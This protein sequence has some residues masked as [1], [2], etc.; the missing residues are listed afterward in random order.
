MRRPPILMSAVQR[1]ETVFGPDVVRFLF[2]RIED[3]RGSLYPVDLSRLPF[4]P[5]HMFFICRAPPGTARGGHARKTT[6]Q[7]LLC[8][9]G[10]IDVAVHHRGRRET[11]ELT[12]PG[13]AIYL[14]PKVWSEQTYRSMDASLFVLSSGH[15]DPDDYL[16]EP[17]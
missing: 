2:D 8:V 14:R 9:A 1:V 12:Q 5:A 3:S 17:S 11:F 6:E 10:Q 4:S 15:F 13:Q 16:R 7:L